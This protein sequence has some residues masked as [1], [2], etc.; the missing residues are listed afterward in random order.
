[1]LKATNERYE[2]E[3]DQQINDS[4]EEKLKAIVID[5]YPKGDPPMTS[6]EPCIIFMSEDREYG[7]KP[8]G[9]IEFENIENL[10]LAQVGLELLFKAILDE[11]A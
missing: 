8:F 11:K 9:Y 2:F 1:M 10:E 3:F 4:G 5:V 7:N 6:D